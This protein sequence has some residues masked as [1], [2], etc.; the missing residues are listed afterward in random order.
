[1]QAQWRGSRPSSS[2][3]NVSL[4]D[5]ERREVRTLVWVRRAA[6]WSGN[7]SSAAG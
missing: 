7:L 4:G 6:V 2:G 5:V 1:M 3:F